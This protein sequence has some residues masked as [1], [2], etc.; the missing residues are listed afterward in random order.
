MR[1]WQS[2]NADTCHLSNPTLLNGQGY[3]VGVN[4]KVQNTGEPMPN[5]FVGLDF[6]FFGGCGRGR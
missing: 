2:L 5:F 4:R 3:W 6:K 1:T